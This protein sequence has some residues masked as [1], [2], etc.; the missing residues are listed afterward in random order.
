[1]VVDTLVRGMSEAFE[2]SRVRLSFLSFYPPFLLGSDLRFNYGQELKE[3]SRRKSLFIHHESG[4]WAMLARQWALVEEANKRLSKKSAEV[5]ELHVVHAAVREEAAQAREAKAK[6]CEDAARAREEAAKAREDL[7]SLLA[8]VKELEE[9]VALVSGQRDALNVQI[10]MA[11]ACIGTLENEVATLKGAVQERDEALLGIGR[12]IEALRAT[13]RDKD[14]ALRG[15]EMAC[16]ELR[17]EVVGWQTH[18]KGK[19]FVVF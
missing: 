12:E 13:V 15:V 1:M 11:S 9:D 4:V 10:G 8:R 16:E 6:A 3:R 19:P 14:K 18:A 2:V 7:A 5:D 17:D